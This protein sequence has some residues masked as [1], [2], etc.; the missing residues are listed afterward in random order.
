MGVLTIHA[1]KDVGIP[2]GSEPIEFGGVMITHIKPIN[3]LTATVIYPVVIFVSGMLAGVLPALRAS[4]LE[5]VSAIRE[6]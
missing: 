1:L 6:H 3:V 4:R 5:P 2:L